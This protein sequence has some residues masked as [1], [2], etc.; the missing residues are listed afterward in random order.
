MARIPDEAITRIKQDI[1]LARLVESAG[2]ALKPHGK[3]LLG[4]CPFHDDHTPSLVITPDKN[5]WHC[6]GAC[7]KGGSVIDWVQQMHGVSFTQAFHMLAEHSPALAAVNRP[8]KQATTPKL[9]NPL[10][11]VEDAALL[12]QVIDYYHDE[13]KKSPEALAYLKQRGL[14][15]PEMID[16]FK[17]GF[18]NRTLA[19]RLPEKNRKAGAQIRTQLQ[20][21]GIL[22]ESGHEHFNGSLVIPIIN[23]HQVKEVYGRKINHQLRKGTPMHLY[24]PGA[25]QGIFN[26]EALRAST[27]IILCESLG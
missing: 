10:T 24:L 26:V 27:E 9:T 13:L 16:H 18:A 7:G 15:H 20:R 22:R 3:D 21:I 25:H 17:L 12:N 19:Y 5:L 11:A 23:H 4:L 1:S 8:I 14:N 2:I 6:L